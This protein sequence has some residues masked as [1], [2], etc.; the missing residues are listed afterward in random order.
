MQCTSFTLLLR[1]I[2]SLSNKTGNRESRRTR[3]IWPTDSVLVFIVIDRFYDRIFLFMFSGPWSQTALPHP[4]ISL[5]LSAP[6]LAVTASSLP[7]TRTCAAPQT[8]T[9]THGSER[10][11]WEGIR[12]AFWLHQSLKTDCCNFR[13]RVFGNSRTRLGHQNSFNLLMGTV[14]S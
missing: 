1:C 12:G 13:G 2:F 6:S 9:C 8:Y 14:I 4:L 5:T 11:G 3:L 10:E 7:F